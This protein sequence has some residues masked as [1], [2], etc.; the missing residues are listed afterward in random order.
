[1]HFDG[2]AWT[3]LLPLQSASSAPL[4]SVWG[5]S[6]NDVW[7]VGPDAGVLHSDGTGWAMSTAAIGPLTCV[8]GTGP[9]DV[10]AVGPQDTLHFDG[11]AWSDRGD[12]GLDAGLVAVWAATPDTPWGASGYSALYRW[13]RDAGWS[14]QYDL[15][16]SDGELP[17]LHPT[18]SGSGPND[19]YVSSD[20]AAAHFDGASWA[21]LTFATNVIPGARLNTIVRVW[22][23][24]PNLAVLDDWQ[25]QGMYEGDGFQPWHLLAPVALSKVTSAAMGG[26]GPDDVW[27]LSWNDWRAWHWDGVAWSATVLPSS[28]FWGI[29]AV[30]PHNVFVVGDNGQVL[31]LRH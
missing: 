26:S 15:G 4:Y 3:S 29:S 16:G 23:I 17:M 28:H 7:A 14:F 22:G 11:T 5:S 9:S 8:H 31:H 18:F 10:W 1:M 20:T 24:G 13:Q 2:S 30:D 12:K 27:I 21:P 19:I 25:G 6:V